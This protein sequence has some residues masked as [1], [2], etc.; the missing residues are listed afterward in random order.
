MVD[1]VMTLWTDEEEAWTDGVKEW[2]D[3]GGYL[4]PEPVYSSNPGTEIVDGVTY[5]VWQDWK[6]SAVRLYQ[7]TDEQGVVHYYQKVED[8]SSRRGTRYRLHHEGDLSDRTD[9]IG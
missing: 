6:D 1:G 8:T 2:T 4:A 9:G 3:E 5:E 7:K